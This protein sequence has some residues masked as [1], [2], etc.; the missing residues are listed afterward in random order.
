MKVGIVAGAVA[1][2]VVVGF[3]VAAA[4]LGPSLYAGIGSSHASSNIGSPVPVSGNPIVVENSHPGTSSWKIPPGKESTKQ[5]QAYANSPYAV[6]GKLFT[7]YVSTQFKSTPYWIDIYRLGWY[8]GQGGRLMAS[9]G[10][11]IGQDQGF[12]DSSLGQLDNCKSCSVHTDTGL[13]EALWQKSYSLTIPASWTSGVYLAKCT[14]VNG[15]QTYVPFDVLPGANQ[16]PT[17]YIAVTPDTTY[18]A[19]NDWGGY[20]LYNAQTGLFAESDTGTHG[21]MVSFDRPYTQESGASEVLVFEANAIHWMEKNGYDVSY[22]SNINIEN[23]PN[24]L[25]QHKAYISLGHDEYWTTKM[26]DAVEGARDK[27][28]GLAFMGAGVSTWQ[29]TFAP[30]SLGQ[31]NHTVVCYKIDSKLGQ[32]DLARDP[33][34]QANPALLTAQWRDAA[35]NRPE[36]AMVGVMYTD[37]TRKQDGFPW[38]VSANANSP[39]LNGTNLQPAQAYGCDLVGYEWDSNV[40]NGAAPKGLQVLS[41]SGVVNDSGKAETSNTTYYIA[42]SGALVFATGSTY[43]TRAL[44]GYRAH[45]DKNCYGHDA[46]IPGMQT[47]MANVMAALITHQHG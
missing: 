4:L 10:H 40:N 24:Q 33:N 25:L 26:R 29:M 5:I 3:L 13:V 42:D 28:V 8:G 27:G 2:F 12:Y 44:D 36:N 23:N 31:P 47:L 38:Q 6:P 41:T 1:F 43:W 20:S 22:I 7:F 46:V 19:Y 35:L 11:L 39:L 18:A 9:S 32:K 17:T 34:A 15:M 45:T 14:D 30:D 16:P 37:L 21:V